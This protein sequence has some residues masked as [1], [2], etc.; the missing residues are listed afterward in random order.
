MSSNSQWARET[1]TTI[2]KH[3]GELENA[4]LRKYKTFTLIDENGNVSFNNGGLG[5]DWE[6]RFRNHNVVGNNGETRRVWN[7]QNLWQTAELDYRGYQL[8]DSITTKELESNKGP[9]AKIKLAAKMVSRMEGSFNDFLSRQVWIDGNASGNELSWHGVES[10]M[11]ATQTIN[12]STGAAR[13]ANAADPVGY[14][15]DSYAGLSTVLGAVG[16]AQTSGVWPAGVADHEFDYYTPVIVN[17]TSTYFG[18]AT[19]TWKNQCIEAM[20]FGLFHTKRNDSQDEGVDMIVL[21]RALYVDFLNRQDSK[22]RVIV[23]DAKRL[24]NFGFNDV[25]SF[26]GGVEV[27]TEYGVPANCGYLLNTKKMEI[28]CM[29]GKLLSPDP[30]MPIYNEDYQEYRY[31]LSTLSNLKFASPRNFGKLVALT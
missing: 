7:R 14:S 15:N 26:D 20:R 2:V 4:A 17:Y 19:P 25:V 31:A 24:R 1:A 3:F 23:S 9:Q 29:Q 6:V 8:T 5:F 11:N 10:F 21:D 18:G 13:T 28:L 30:E 22:E 27:T 16:G 12:V